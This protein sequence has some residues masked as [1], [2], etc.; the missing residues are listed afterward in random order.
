MVNREKKVFILLAAMLA[1][2]MILHFVSSNKSLR[3]ALTESYKTPETAIEESLKTSEYVLVTQDGTGF[4][5]CKTNENNY[6]CQYLLKTEDGW[7]VVTSAI[8]GNS[9]YYKEYDD[10]GYTLCIREY[11]DT[12]M[13]YLLQEESHISKNGLLKVNDSLNSNY[14]EFDYA[15][16]FGGHYW[17]WVV[18]DLPDGY[19]IKINNTEVF[20]K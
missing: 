1:V 15:S 7:K 14:E 13:I 11:K 9:Y 6:N 3:I 12:Y 17:Y 2:F 19:T 20:N 5:C 4:A 10:H 16:I 18:K 8:F